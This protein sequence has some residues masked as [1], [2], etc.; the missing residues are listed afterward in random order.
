MA[1]YNL[2]AEQS[3]LGSILIEPES[4]L[5]ANLI[6]TFIT[7]NIKLYTSSMTGVQT[8]L[9]EKLE[10]SHIYI[11]TSAVPTTSHNIHKTKYIQLDAKH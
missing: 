1:L 7:H 5:V 9:L 11:T 6:V 3:V 8:E 10:E 2:Y 4:I